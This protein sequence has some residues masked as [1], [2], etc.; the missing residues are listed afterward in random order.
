[1]AKGTVNLMCKNMELSLNYN[2][3]I[4]PPI[5]TIGGFYFRSNKSSCLMTPKPLYISYTLFFHVFWRL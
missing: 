4:K 2:Y 1:M 5:S 3:D